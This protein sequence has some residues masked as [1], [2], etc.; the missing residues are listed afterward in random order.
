MPHERGW[1]TRQVVLPTG[2]VVFTKIERS[3][4]WWWV[5][6]VVFLLL[7]FWVIL[8]NPVLAYTNN[9]MTPNTCEQNS[10][11][12]IGGKIDFGGSGTHAHFRIHDT[13]HTTSTCV[14]YS[15]NTDFTSDLT[16]PEVGS[17]EADYQLYSNSNCTTEV[18][19]YDPPVSGGFTVTEAGEEPPASEST[20]TATGTSADLFPVTFAF[21]I[22]LFILT[23]WSGWFL[24]R[25][26]YAR[27]IL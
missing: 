1:E 2:E 12:N 24:C 13:N 26:R 5:A 6:V 10:T 11:C 17:F 18:V 27:L 16:P 8:T 19:T 25:R 9:T 20:S 15:V 7:T 23:F 22:L 21:S 14:A 3:W 4:F